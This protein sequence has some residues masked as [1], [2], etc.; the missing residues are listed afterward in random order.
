MINW[1]KGWFRLLAVFL[2]VSRLVVLAALLWA[3]VTVVGS[4]GGSFS[5]E[6]QINAAEVMSNEQ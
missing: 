4:S 6:W 3:L 2:M 1:C 5:V